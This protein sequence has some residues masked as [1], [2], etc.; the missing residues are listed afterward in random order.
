MHAK[1]AKLFE[2]VQ[3]RREELNIINQMI[4]AKSQQQFIPSLNE[5]RTKMNAL[6][7][8]IQKL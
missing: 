5:V 1:V 2:Y 6:T 8:E 3:L 4:E 7:L